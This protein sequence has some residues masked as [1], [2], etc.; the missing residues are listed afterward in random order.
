MFDAD[1]LIVGGGSAGSVLAA[2]LSED[3]GR[4]VTLIEAGRD[5]PPGGVPADIADVF[6]R[7][8][9][10]PAYFWPGLQAVA[11]AAP[12]AAPIRRRG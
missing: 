5:L 8:Y 9:A 12:A 1:F 11:R 10:N 4:R 6:P 2:R 3:A 7:A